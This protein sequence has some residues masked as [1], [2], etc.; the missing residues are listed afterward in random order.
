MNRRG[1]LKA[2]LAA[3]VAPY[4]VTTAGVLMPVRS[5]SGEV[6]IDLIVRGQVTASFVRAAMLQGA[7]F[8]ALGKVQRVREMPSSSFALG[9]AGKVAAISQAVI[10][11]HLS[12]IRTE[13]YLRNC[14]GSAL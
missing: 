7:A 14:F 8:A 3:G 11:G 4:V 6:S 9:Y 5:L 2:I 1:L 13:E 10:D 12:I